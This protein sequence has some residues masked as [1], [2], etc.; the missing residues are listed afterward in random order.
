MAN[1][2]AGPVV[3]EGPGATGASMCMTR[4]LERYAQV[5]Q[6]RRE[7]RHSQGPT[8]RRPAAD[9]I[10]YDQPVNQE[11]VHVCIVW[12]KPPRRH[13][14]DVR[15]L[16]QRGRRGALRG[17]GFQAIGEKVEA[18]EGEAARKHRELASLSID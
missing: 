3:H 6:G 9:V 15:V 13:G 11:R 4:C 16:Q 8:W 1:M 7:A 17:I 2:E 12:V 5:P 18:R 14:L 10:G